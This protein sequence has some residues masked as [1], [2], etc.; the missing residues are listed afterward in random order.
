MNAYRYTISLRIRHPSIDV[1]EIASNLS[2][3]PFRSWQAGEPRSTPKGT[4]I[5]GVNSETYWTTRVAEGDS[6]S[7]VLSVVL[8]G[9][10]ADLA[11]HRM[12]FER[13]RREGASIELF[14]GWYFGGNSG[15]IFGFDLLA[16]LADLKIDLSLD[17]YPSDQA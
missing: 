16:K 11:R 13:L 6:S 12:F 17:V 8:L 10:V 1:A 5:T 7:A 15:D 14:V 9:L 2:R 3:E 4:P